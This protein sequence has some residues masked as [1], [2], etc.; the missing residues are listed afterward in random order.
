M[1]ISDGSVPAGPNLNGGMEPELNKLASPPPLAST[2]VNNV[3]S[4]FYVPP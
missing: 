3:S 4:F 1:D 2:S